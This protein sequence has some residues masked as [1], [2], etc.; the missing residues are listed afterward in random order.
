MSGAGWGGSWRGRRRGA[1]AGLGAGEGLDCAE[2]QE[3]SPQAEPALAKR[4]SV[5]GERSC[6]GAREV[7]QG[8]LGVSPA[9]GLCS[10]DDAVC[11][12]NAG[13]RR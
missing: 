10:L 9:F 8:L 6:R 4:C 12:G 13:K 11:S 2:K 3:G 1:G 5:L 7:G